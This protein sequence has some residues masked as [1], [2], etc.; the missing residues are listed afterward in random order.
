MIIVHYVSIRDG[1]LLHLGTISCN[2]TITL[3]LKR[4]KLEKTFS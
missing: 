1:H 2:L 3:D 4:E